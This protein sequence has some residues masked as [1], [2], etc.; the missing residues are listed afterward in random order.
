MIDQKLKIKNEVS[1]VDVAKGYSIK[2]II[3]NMSIKLPDFKVGNIVVST[4]D[5]KFDDSISI[6]DAKVSIL[7]LVQYI[8]QTKNT[9]ELLN[10]RI[11]NI[12]EGYIPKAKSEKIE[13]LNAK[14][15]DISNNIISKDNDI[16]TIEL[17]SVDETSK[18][19]ISKYYDINNK[20]YNLEKLLDNVLLSKDE[21]E[22]IEKASINLEL[23]S[24][25]YLKEVSDEKDKITNDLNIELLLNNTSV[26]LKNKKQF[27]DDYVINSM[28]STNM[29]DEENSQEKIDNNYELKARQYEV[30]SKYILDYEQTL[31]NNLDEKIKYYLPENTDENNSDVKNISEEE[32]KY[33]LQDVIKIYN[34]FISKENKFYLDNL[35]YILRDTTYKLSKLPEYTDA[36]TVKDVKYIYI[37]LP[38]EID[39]LLEEYN[40]KSTLQTEVLAS[41]L[42]QRLLKIVKSNIQVN[43]EYDKFNLS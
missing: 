15:Q 42:S 35:N 10:K 31:I 21:L 30:T 36:N 4:R 2:D 5:V 32:K 39:V 41:N 3:N 19:I 13:S 20:I 40:T 9:S 12:F 8:S 11:N 33:L 7:K 1:T 26:A 6:E 17:I 38:E 23:E 22:S 18:S 37:N 29:N 43:V 16:L 25:N 14:L 28:I 27:L 24:V 34:D